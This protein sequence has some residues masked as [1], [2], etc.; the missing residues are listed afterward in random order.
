MFNWYRLINQQ[1]FLDTNLTSYEVT[2]SLEDIGETSLMI[3]RGVGVSIVYDN[4]IYPVNLNG[5]NPF[6]FG[7]RAVNLDANGDIWFG[8]YVED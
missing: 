8:V 2:V 1:A 5:K 4:E 7:L 6:R 3:V